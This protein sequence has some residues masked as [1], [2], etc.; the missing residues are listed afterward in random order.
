MV[1]QE[2]KNKEQGMKTETEQERK[3]TQKTK[4]NAKGFYL[5]WRGRLHHEG[6]VYF[7]V[8]KAVFSRIFVGMIFA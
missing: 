1:K 3:E 7:L 4:C 8:M 2:T 6:R 5:F